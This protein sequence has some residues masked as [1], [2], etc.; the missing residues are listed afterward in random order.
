MHHLDGTP[1]VRPNRRSRCPAQERQHSATAHHV[2]LLMGWS[3]FGFRARF[4]LEHPRAFLSAAL[5]S[6]VLLVG[7]LAANRYRAWTMGRE[8]A[9]AGLPACEAA[10]GKDG[11]AAR[12]ETDHAPCF[13]WAYTPAGK[14]SSERVEHS[15]YQRCLV[16]GV[17]TYEQE[18]AETLRREAEQHR[19]LVRE[20]LQ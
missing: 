5:V 7:L 1:R 4:A 12:M 14:Y 8:L 3:M 16:V 20:V 17:Q 10:L 15:V 19:T 13:R 6:V 9:A 11:C 18:R 2:L